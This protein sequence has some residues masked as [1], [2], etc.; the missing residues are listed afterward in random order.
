LPRPENVCALC[1]SSWG[2]VWRTIDGRR[3]FFCCKVCERE[4][5][6]TLKEIKK[7]TGWK[8]LEDVRFEGGRRGR[9]C[10]A[11]SG[12]KSYTLI[13]SYDRAGRIQFASEAHSER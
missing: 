2:D 11:K 7:R 8:K 13:A 6:V 1:G 12:E 4:Y 3:L 10:V 5:L 9:R